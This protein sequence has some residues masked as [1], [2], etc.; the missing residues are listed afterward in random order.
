M[1]SGGDSVVF[2]NKRSDIQRCSVLF[3]VYDYGAWGGS[4]SVS[5]DL[6]QLPLDA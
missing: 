4:A 6:P 1:G 3:V 2:V 5:R